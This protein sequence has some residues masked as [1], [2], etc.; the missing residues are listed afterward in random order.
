[1]ATPRCRWAARN[2]CASRSGQRWL[3]FVAVLAPLVM[4]FP[5]VTIAAPLVRTLT[6][7]RKK[8]CVMVAVGRTVRAPVTLPAAMT[9]SWKANAASV[10]TGVRSGR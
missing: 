7:D 4:E 9:F 10:V 1:L 5:S 6:P 2:R 8:Y 3:A